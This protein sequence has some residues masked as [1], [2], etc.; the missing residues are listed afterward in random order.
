MVVKMNNTS[1][2]NEKHSLYHDNGSKFWYSGRVSSFVANSRIVMLF[3]GKE[4]DC[5]YDKANIS[6]VICD[7][8]TL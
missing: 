2:R 5:D 6:I 4:R 1:L 7:I 8:D 3:W